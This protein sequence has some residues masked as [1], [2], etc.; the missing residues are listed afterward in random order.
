MD[1]KRLLKKAK[2]F[3]FKYSGSVSGRLFFYTV[4]P[5]TIITAVLC[6]LYSSYLLEYR[7][8]IFLQKSHID[9]YSLQPSLQYGVYT[10][11]Y[12]V[13]D[14]AIRRL[15]SRELKKVSFVSNAGE[16]IYPTVTCG[17][18]QNY[19]TQDLESYKVQF[20]PQSAKF[21]MP[22]NINNLPDFVDEDDFINA[23]ENQRLGWVVFEYDLVEFWHDYQNILLLAIIFLI[24]SVLICYLITRH[25]ESKITEP[26]LELIS[27]LRLLE[28][29]DFKLVITKSSFGEMSRLQF[30]AKKMAQSL[31]L[32]HQGLHNKI[33]HATQSLRASVI[34]VEKQKQQL[35]IAHK[36]SEKS[37]ESKSQFLAHISHEYKTPLNSVIGFVDLMLQD[38]LSVKHRSYCETIKN[39]ANHLLTMIDD[40]LDFNLIEAGKLAIREKKI[41]LRDCIEEVINTLNPLA[42]EKNLPVN[43]IFYQDVPEY[44]VSDR[45]RL[46]QVLINLIS[47]AIKF[48]DKGYILI[49][50]ALSDQINLDDKKEFIQITVQDT[51]NGISP[52][53]EKNLFSPFC[54]TQNQPTFGYS[55]S[56]LGLVITKKIVTLLGGSI[57]Y[58]T[59][60]GVGT[61]FYINLPF[62]VVEAGKDPIRFIY[63]KDTTVVI[64]DKHR[65][66]P[67][68]HHQVTYLNFAV[69]HLA[70]FELL[71]SKKQ[72]YSIYLFSCHRHDD[73]HT[74]IKYYKLL[75]I[76]MNKIYIYSYDQSLIS[77]AL[78]KIPGLYH[79]FTLPV[80]TPDLHAV[81]M[82]REHCPQSCNQPSSTM[83]QVLVVDDNPINT[84]LLSSYLE[85]YS[86]RVTVLN[87]S[88]KFLNLVTISNFD[89]IFLDIFMPHL[90]GV[91]CIRALQTSNRS[92]YKT[93]PIIAVTANSLANDDD[94]L[95]KEG[96][97]EVMYKPLCPQFIDKLLKKYLSS[98]C[99][100]EDI[101]RFSL[102]SDEQYQV[103]VQ[104]RKDMRICMDY[105][106]QS[107]L[108]DLSNCIHALLGLVGYSQSF[109]RIYQLLS[110][111]EHLLQ[112]DTI[113]KRKVLRYLKRISVE[114]YKIDIQKYS[115]DS[116]CQAREV[117][118]V[119]KE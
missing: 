38:N 46:H 72:Q 62:E 2:L 57:N 67:A 80:K 74:I 101:K 47:N 115:R 65:I 66:A 7:Q 78:R 86:L 3:L 69:E 4:I 34:Q 81:L 48:T 43:Y 116:L 118:C 59:S 109:E 35:E 85:R 50:V 26:I 15:D 76:P 90:D 89:I 23:T 37:S 6:A 99:K 17:S 73:I 55:G 92:Y 117:S 22:L 9:F 83:K 42:K 56:G 96:F 31:R 28:S 10:N 54:H 63:N 119:F 51:G 68:V 91:N 20:T 11:N 112:G 71:S 24:Q 27:G 93:V 95:Y 110:Q 29:N 100:D 94:R 60:I 32:A 13:V 18:H 14:T 105:Y 44:V 39:S 106:Y 25:V 88:R 33:V 21:I 52:S 104:C 61:K 84:K 103:I 12:S 82:D 111:L 75:K 102:S 114:I 87:D 70:S 113:N 98:P 16:T 64:V 58:E 107:K 49:R 97:C 8:T 77:S 45:Y 5:S 36:K 1:I 41:N 40:I 108:E 19:K 30:S 53:I 79:T